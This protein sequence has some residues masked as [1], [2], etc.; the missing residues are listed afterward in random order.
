MGN[1]LLPQYYWCPLTEHYWCHVTTNI[2]VNELSNSS[3]TS[4]HFSKKQCTYLKKNQSGLNPQWCFVCDSSQI[5]IFALRQITLPRNI[6]KYFQGILGH[7]YCMSNIPGLLISIFNVMRQLQDFPMNLLLKVCL[8]GLLQ[9]SEVSFFLY[10]YTF[11]LKENLYF[12]TKC[13]PN[14]LVQNCSNYIPRK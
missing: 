8:H 11:A 7:N 6:L 9:N 13:N 1:L 4:H 5:Q 2:C 10:V 12:S 3:V 14:I